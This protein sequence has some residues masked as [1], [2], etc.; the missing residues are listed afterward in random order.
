MLKISTKQLQFLV[1]NMELSEYFYLVPTQEVM[2]IATVV[3]DQIYHAFV[4]DSCQ[5]KLIKLQIC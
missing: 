1:P 3:A 5:D 2:R 4:V